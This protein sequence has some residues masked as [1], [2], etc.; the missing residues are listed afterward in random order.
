MSTLDQTQIPCRFRERAFRTYEPIIA[1]VIKAYPGV[2]TFSPSLN[3]SLS[4]DTFACRFRD[5]LRSHERYNWTTQLIDRERFLACVN[6]IAVSMTKE[7]GLLRIGDRAELRRPDAAILNSPARLGSSFAPSASPLLRLDTDAEC[8]LICK[9]ATLR[10]LAAELKCTG[11]SEQTKHQY[12][13]K[14]DVSI[15]LDPATGIAGVL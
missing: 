6:S 9:L 2:I 12:E 1:Q 5:A 11:F 8:D 7:N 13:L 14:Y 15:D 3:Y 10:L 4:P